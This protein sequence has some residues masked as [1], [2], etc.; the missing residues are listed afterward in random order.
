MPE[1]EN[2]AISE[3]G[4]FEIRLKGAISHLMKIARQFV[5]FLVFPT[6]LTGCGSPPFIT[7]SPNIS[8]PDEEQV[9]SV[10]YNAN[11][12][13][14]DDIRALAV[15]ECTVEGSGL[16]FWHHDKA[17]NDCPILAKARVSFL[18]IPPPK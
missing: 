12:T 8:P 17:L 3:P 18:C 14:R 6:L 9:V 5:M 4:C 10:C 11:N 13:T 2:S 1:C 15:K 7:S 16:E